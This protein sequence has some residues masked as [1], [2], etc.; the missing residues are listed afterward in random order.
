MAVNATPQ[1]VLVNPYA[2]PHSPTGA[3]AHATH[4]WMVMVVV[5]KGDIVEWRPNYVEISLD[6][7]AILSILFTLKTM[8][9]TH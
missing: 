6:L 4:T 2:R 9:F 3:R 8:P 1:R 7:F 5:V